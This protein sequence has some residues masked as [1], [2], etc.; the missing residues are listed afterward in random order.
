[1]HHAVSINPANK[2]NCPKKTDINIVSPKNITMNGY[3][4]GCIGTKIVFWIVF[5]IATD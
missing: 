5:K 1:M 4:A 3:P 2:K